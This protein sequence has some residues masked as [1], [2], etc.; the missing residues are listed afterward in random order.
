MKISV[1]FDSVKIMD[2]TFVNV[3]HEVM[4][5]GHR[6]VVI[7]LH[8]HDGFLVVRLLDADGKMLP[9]ATGQF[10]ANPALCARPR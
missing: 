8:E 9:R 3:G 6:A 5:F 1:N 2:G 4:N 7:G 10:M